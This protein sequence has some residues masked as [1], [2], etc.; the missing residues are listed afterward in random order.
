MGSFL[1]NKSGKTDWLPLLGVALVVWILVG[2]GGS[3]SQSAGGGAAGGTGQGAGNTVTVVGA[4]CTQSTTLT[5]S[6]IRRYTEAAQTAQNVTIS[7]N[8]VLKTPIA[9]GGTTT[10]QSGPN[11]DKLDLYVVEDRS[12]TFYTQ[13]VKG[14][15]D[16]CTGSATTGDPSFKFVT[17]ETVGGSGVAYSDFP[18]KVIQI[19]TAPTI[20]V[21]NDDPNQVNDG[22]TAGTSG[23]TNLT[24][25]Q[26]SSNSVTVTFRPTYNTGI[27]A[28]GG[29]I[30]ACQFPSAVY[31]PTNPLIVAQDGSPL[32]TSSVVPS[33]TIYPLISA[34]NTVK[35]WKVNGIDG[36]LTTKAQFGIT[37]KA[38][39][40]NDPSG[41]L[42]RIN[43]SLFDTD[44][45]QRQA[46]GK[47]VL[48]IENRDTNADMGGANTVFDFVA[49]V[50]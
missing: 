11:A 45:Y 43:C 41:H 25:G 1:K 49:G 14:T 38:N 32:A 19:D 13:H 23:A 47:F 4:P 40:L 30:L 37:A 16:T 22:N 17:D 39:S 5:A 28:I 33:S 2:Q 7:Q 8:G 26:G 34:N 46:D 42:D 27:G 10:V 35:A 36:R 12:T 31:D 24:I 9:H 18:N 15:L 6:V 48:D 21:Q 50:A 29:N 3:T 20:S 44:Y